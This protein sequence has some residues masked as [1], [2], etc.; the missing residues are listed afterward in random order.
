MTCLKTALCSFWAIVIGSGEQVHGRRYSVIRPPG[1]WPASASRRAFSAA[2]F[3][4]FFLT[5]ASSPSTN[6]SF[7]MVPSPSVSCSTIT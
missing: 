5:S 1:A 7:D 6:S 4:C 3:A 2:C